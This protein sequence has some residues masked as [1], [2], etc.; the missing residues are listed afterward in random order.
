MHRTPYGTV[1]AAGHARIPLRGHHL[2]SYWTEDGYERTELLGLVIAHVNELRWGKIIDTGWTDWDLSLYCHR[3]TAI[4]LCTT[5]ENHGGTKRLIHVRYRVR[6]RNHTKMLALA[7]LVGATCGVALWTWLPALTACLL[8]L[9][10][11]AVWWHGTR[12]ASQAV[13]VVD[14]MAAT[15]GLVRCPPGDRKDQRPRRSLWRKAIALWRNGQ[16][17]SPPLMVSGQTRSSSSSAP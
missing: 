5:Q 4:Q 14:Q 8:L 3:W 10:L 15:L 11:L 1:P 17:L 16:A 7:G 6:L 13:A 12:R 9:F 2:A